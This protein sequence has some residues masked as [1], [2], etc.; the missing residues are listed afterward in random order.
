MTTAFFYLFF[1][2]VFFYTKV[3]ATKEKELFEKNITRKICELYQLTTKR[4]SKHKNQKYLIELDAGNTCTID[5]NFLSF[6]IDAVEMMRH[7]RCFPSKSA[8]VNILA[9]GLSPAYLRVGGSPQDFMT[10]IDDENKNVNIKNSCEPR[11]ESWRTLK[12]FKLSSRYFEEI[13]VFAKVNH[14][15]LIIGLNAL[16]RK[17]NN[18]WDERNAGEIMKFMKNKN[19]STIWTLGNEPNRFKKY[20]STFNISPRQLVADVLKLRSMTTHGIYGPDIS[21]P[22]CKSLR[23][24]KNFLKNQPR[25][26][27]LT[28]HHYNMHQNLSTVEMFLNPS[29]LEKFHEENSWIRSL[30]DK[31]KVK[32]DLWLGETGSA[33]GGGA[34]NL[35]DTF[36]SGF[37]YLGKLG[38]ASA[39]CHK[40][41]IR[42]S[43]YGG[44]YGMLDAISLDPLPDYWSAFLFK[45]LVGRFL[46]SHQSFNDGYLRI[47][48]Y[49]AQN[50]S[51]QLV[52]MAVNF[53]LE[54]EAILQVKKFSDNLVEK[55]ILTAPKNNLRSKLVLLNG[56]L[57][58]LN[59][60]GNLP[61]LIGNFGTQPFSLPAKSYGFFVVQDIQISDCK[62]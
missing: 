31:E 57:V 58:T 12:P 5:K 15:D 44:H 13:G 10:F 40:V 23:Y 49:C 25:L 60:D 47:F 1:N 36:A 45:K 9:R 30:I 41:V 21:H 26:D 16:K 53:D 32:V 42:Q 59:A 17:P 43:F 27:A 34:K 50:S 46:L 14:L 52:I 4:P 24:L 37:L 62:R 18:S 33:S 7:F 48:T 2:F 61:T 8:K 19:L 11:F 22:T 28:Y 54:D 3:N 51:T 38:V 35:S 29:F 55:F 20:G 6:S 56:E 39:D